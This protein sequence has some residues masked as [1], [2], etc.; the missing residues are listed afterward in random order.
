MTLGAPFLARG[1][2]RIL[3]SADRSKVFE[4]DFND[5]LGMQ[6]SGA[7]FDWPMCPRKDGGLED[8]SRFSA[9]EASGGLTAHRMNPGGGSCVLCG[10]VPAAPARVWVLL[11]TQGFP[12]AG[13]MRREPPASGCA[14]DGTGLALGMDFGVS[15]LVE[16]RREMVERGRMFDTPCFRWAGA[17]G[18][19]T[20]GYCAFLRA[21]DA[22]PG[23]LGWDGA[24]EVELS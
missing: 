5:G 4:K 2:T 20:G 22:L 6:V 12:V 8:L 16:T 9:E 10:V 15:P 23:G 7:G 14:L 21:A 13:G 17:L 3:L 19:V 11:A 1:E 24:G 18:S